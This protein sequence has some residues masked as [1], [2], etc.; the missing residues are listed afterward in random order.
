MF[1][2]KA[3]FSVGAMTV[4]NRLFSLT[5]LMGGE[6]EIGVIYDYDGILFDKVVPNYFLDGCLSMSHEVAWFFK[7]ILL[8][9][10]ESPL[11]CL[12]HLRLAYF[13]TSG[14]IR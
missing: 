3:E 10:L 14:D 2:V 12:Y 13:T 5:F 11:Y 1:C 9:V 6:A 8:N 7:S 4:I